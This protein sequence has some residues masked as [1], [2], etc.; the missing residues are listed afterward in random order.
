MMNKTFLSSGL[1]S[2]EVKEV[3]ILPLFY[4]IT[5]Q[6]F[7][8]ILYTFLGL[9]VDC[10]PLEIFTSDTNDDSPSE[11]DLGR[12][13]TVEVGTAYSQTDSSVTPTSSVET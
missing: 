1:E 13:H 11:S 7:Y 8:V 12:G 6:Y 5:Q 4:R 9:Y 3:D 10:E 2:L